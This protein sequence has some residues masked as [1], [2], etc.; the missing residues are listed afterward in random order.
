MLG[1]G[2][3]AGERQGRRGSAELGGSLKEGGI[4]RRQ[5]AGV[6]L[7]LALSLSGALSLFLQDE[8]KSEDVYVI[9]IQPAGL[10]SSDVCLVPPSTAQLVRSSWVCGPTNPN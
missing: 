3:A 2:A 8:Q 5:V 9:L 1:R 10:K 7:C 6:S 4:G